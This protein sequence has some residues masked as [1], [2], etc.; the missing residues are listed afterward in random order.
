M[1]KIN[2]LLFLLFIIA[3]YQ[4]ILLASTNENL[5]LKPCIQQ[6]IR[7]GKVWRGQVILRQDI[8][9]KKSPTK[10]WVYQNDEIVN[11]A[12]FTEAKSIGNKM[13][14]S[15]SIDVPAQVDFILKIYTHGH[16]VENQT[17]NT[18]KCNLRQSDCLQ[19]DII[20]RWVNPDLN[21]MLD[22]ILKDILQ[23]IKPESYFNA[24]YLLNILKKSALTFEDLNK[25]NE[26]QNQLKNIAVSELNLNGQQ[27][28]E[29]DQNWDIIEQIVQIKFSGNEIPQD[30]I[31]SII[32]TIK[33]DKMPLE[34]REDAIGL[35]I[36]SN[37]SEIN[38]IGIL[39]YLREKA[40]NPQSELYIQ[41][42]VGL[43]IIGDASDQQQFDANKI[44]VTDKIFAVGVLTALGNIVL[45]S[46]NKTEENRIIEQFQKVINKDDF[47]LTL[48]E[49]AI[50]KLGNFTNQNNSE[51]GK[52]LL[53][54]TLEKKK[55]LRLSTLQA[56]IKDK[57]K[58]P[59][60][61]KVLKV[62][63]KLKVSN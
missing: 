60:L 20:S 62:E 28:L 2:K 47:D 41:S 11:C 53:V 52:N 49:I 14:R 21:K 39:K 12:K 15:Y 59:Q 50:Q 30:R 36:K 13:V 26:T 18:K 45:D 55:V 7:G 16:I 25:I 48:R 43:F 40:L 29:Q 61:K 33:D 35:I 46:T 24:I 38:K 10:I 23:N 1:S 54:R 44:L 51:A 58:L 42:L 31:A 57:L 56:I 19:S 22:G 8:Y 5:T 17:H 27:I 37:L 9:D 3:L 32:N 63:N 4:S 6:N 34:V